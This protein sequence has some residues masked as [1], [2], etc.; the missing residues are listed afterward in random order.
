MIKEEVKCENCNHCKEITGSGV[1]C[2][3]KKG[4]LWSRPQFCRY[5]EDDDLIRLKLFG[6]TYMKLKKGE[7]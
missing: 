5:Y 1:V 4:I 2:C 6:E 7:Y 3:R